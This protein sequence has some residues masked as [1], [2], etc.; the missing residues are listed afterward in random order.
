VEET[1]RAHAVQCV[2]VR[3]LCVAAGERGVR[4][5]AGSRTEGNG[6]HACGCGAHAGG[7]WECRVR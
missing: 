3:D 5:C 2:H 1:G 6:V 7:M 4:T